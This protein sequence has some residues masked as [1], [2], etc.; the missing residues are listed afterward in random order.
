MTSSPRKL[1]TPGRH[2]RILF[3]SPSAASEQS[4]LGVTARP[5]FERVALPARLW[6]MARLA[7]LAA[8]IPDEE[9]R[10][11]IIAGAIAT[12]SP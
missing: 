3:L 2:L 1:N 5:R 11:W 10:H 4:G 12:R 8:L 6:R 7:A 9:G